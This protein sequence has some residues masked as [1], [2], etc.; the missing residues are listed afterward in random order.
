MYFGS[1]TSFISAAIP[2]SKVSLPQP[3]PSRASSGLFVILSDSTIST[4]FYGSS[5]Y[6]LPTKST[7]T[8]FK[9]KSR[10]S[11]STGREGIYSPSTAPSDSNSLNERSRYRKRRPDPDYPHCILHAASPPDPLPSHPRLDTPPSASFHQR[12]Q[13]YQKQYP[14]LREF[15]SESG[16]HQPQSVRHHPSSGMHHHQPQ[17]HHERDSARNASPLRSLGPHQRQQQQQRH[18]QIHLLSPADHHRQHP[19]PSS[20][21]YDGRSTSSLRTRSAVRNNNSTTTNPTHKALNLAEIWSSLRELDLIVP[22]C[23]TLLKLR[24]Q[25]K[26]QFE[27]GR[28]YSVMELEKWLTECQKYHTQEELEREFLGAQVVLGGVEKRDMGTKRRA[29]DWW[30]E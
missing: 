24:E 9:V 26:H 30:L 27:W 14:S 2:F 23:R 21:K 18:H 17:Q 28:Y 25:Q 22:V 20:S 19:G 6:T 3:F 4:Y 1:Y 8:F 11:S 29:R 15:V 16:L 12:Q 5:S 13:Q 10:Q 7:M